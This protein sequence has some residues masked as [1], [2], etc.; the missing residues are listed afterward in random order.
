M[1]A[2][3][4]TRGRETSAVESRYQITTGEDTAGPGVNVNSRLY[5]D[6]GDK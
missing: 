6:Y 2:V 4:E 5:C 3:R 1:G